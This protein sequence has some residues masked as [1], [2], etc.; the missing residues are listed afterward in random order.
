MTI[1]RDT[2]RGGYGFLTQSILDVDF[3]GIGSVPIYRA[4]FYISMHL[5]QAA[6][7]LLYFTTQTIQMLPKKRID[8]VSAF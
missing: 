2:Y 8:F 7:M 5:K 3:P 4:A 6:L 1:P